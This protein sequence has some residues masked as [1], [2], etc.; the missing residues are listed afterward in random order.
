MRIEKIS[1]EKYISKVKFPEKG[2]SL[3]RES[4][5]ASFVYDDATKLVNNLDGS[6]IA[7]DNIMYE[8]I[9]YFINN[10]HAL[11]YFRNLLI[12]ETV[13]SKQIR[14]PNVR[15]QIY[16]SEPNDDYIHT[17]DKNNQ[18]GWQ[19]DP[20][21]DSMYNNPATDIYEDDNPPEYKVKRGMSEN[22][23][24]DTHSTVNFDK[25]YL[26]LN[27]GNIYGRTFVNAVQPSRNTDKISPPIVHT[28]S[29]D[30]RKI[31]DGRNNLVTLERISG[32]GKISPVSITEK[33]YRKSRV[34]KQPNLIEYL[35]ALEGKQLS[36]TEQSE[37]ITQRFIQKYPAVFAQ[38]VTLKDPT[39]TIELE[40]EI[41][42][43]Y[44]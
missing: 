23:T 4:E 7:Y 14:R 27:M 2:G 25:D 33:S 3:P 19:D 28:V 32:N 8:V 41:T 29:Q 9:R 42:E 1:G 20:E 11:N 10:L 21:L 37:E 12:R 40:I 26:A 5:I 18:L 13:E 17:Y 36:P 38:E 6:Y 43:G 24:D 39:H 16:W 15:P 22:I 35:A 44:K 31:D 30:A 34:G